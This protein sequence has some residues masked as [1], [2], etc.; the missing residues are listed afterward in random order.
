MVHSHPV[1]TFLEPSYHEVTMV[2]IAAPPFVFWMNFPP[3][4]PYMSSL[5]WHLEICS[6][7]NWV[8]MAG[9]QVDTEAMKPLILDSEV[10]NQQNC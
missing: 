10:R 2:T 9:E 4:P 6:P 7:N 1:G 8:L 3:D 5:G